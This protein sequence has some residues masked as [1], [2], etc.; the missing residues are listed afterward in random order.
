MWRS[1]GRQ[2]RKS[3]SLLGNRPVL[4]RKAED[5]NPLTRAMRNRSPA[6]RVRTSVSRLTEREREIYRSVQNAVA[7]LT[8]SADSAF[9]RRL[10]AEGVERV[11]NDISM[12]NFVGDL[13]PMVDALRQEVIR[14]GVNHLPQLPN[15][16]GLRM[17]FDY[18]DP[19]A[20]AWANERAGELVRNLVD[21]QRNMLRNVIS[22]G[23]SDQ[24]TVD[25]MARNVREVVGLPEMWS[26]TVPK[27]RERE[28]AKWIGAGR[29]VTEAARLADRFADGYKQRLVNARAKTIARTEIMTAQNQGRWLS[30]AQGVEQG[31]IPKNAQKEWIA[32]PGFGPAPKT[33]DRCEPLNGLTAKWDEEFP[34]A[35]VLIPPLHPNCRCTAVIVP[36]DVDQLERLLKVPQEE[37]DRAEQ[38]L[39]EYQEIEP[40]VTETVQGWADEL[41]G[42]PVGLDQRFKSRNS[43]ARKT[44]FDSVEK[45]ISPAEASAQIKDALRYTIRVPSDRY[46]EG[47]RDLL[48][49]LQAEGVEVRSKIRWRSPDVYRGVNLQIREPR[50]G[51]WY[52]LQ[53][54]TAESLAA[55]EPLHV[56]FEEYRTLDDSDP[57]KRELFERMVG[58]ADKI[59][60]PKGIGELLGL[61]LS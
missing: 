12:R 29:S 32:A 22:E 40:G 16:V 5:D 36:F 19:R 30:W 42:E 25:E 48:L 21:E 7:A 39:G 47:V 51:R 10:V 44:Y 45:G 50:S 31:F 6:E 34:G 56:L 13:Q 15:G 37:Y 61:I 2:V 52:E 60:N 41:G 35:N 3:R 20:V 57:K 4:I 55:K 46:A 1:K 38:V 27:A 14:A 23:I 17:R 8:N 26:E 18:L 59:P 49:R 43:L 24:I 11:L 9:V 28:F 53:L 58:Q 54:H 33:C